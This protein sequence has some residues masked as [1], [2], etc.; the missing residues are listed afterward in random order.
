MTNIKVILNDDAKIDLDGIVAGLDEQGEGLSAKFK[1]DLDYFLDTIKKNAQ[2]YGH[3]TKRVRI[4]T[5]RSFPH[6]VY[7][8]SVTKDEVHIVAIIHGSRHPNTWRR[9]YKPRE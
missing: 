3:I 2:T 4:A 8:H 9:R 5:L 6:C 1:I 7:F